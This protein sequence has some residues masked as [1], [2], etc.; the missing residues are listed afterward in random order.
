MLRELIINALTINSLTVRLLPKPMRETLSKSLPETHMRREAFYRELRQDFS[1]RSRRFDPLSAEM[2]FNLA[3]TFMRC[4]ALFTERAHATGLTMPALNV[5][6]IL[7][8]HG[9]AGCPLNVLSSLLVVSRANITGLVDSLMRKELVTRTEDREDRR[10][11]LAHITKKG[12]E[13][14][15]SY[16]PTHHG[17]TREIAD[18]LILE[19]K[20][21]LIKLL[22]KI[23]NGLL[24]RKKK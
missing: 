24:S 23:R 13:L 18:P 19:E 21:T 8:K 6:I 10:V 15:A 12:E 7:R 17:I 9:A 4:E 16:M 1:R 5:L 22:T 2:C 14:L 3:Q 20:T 11:V